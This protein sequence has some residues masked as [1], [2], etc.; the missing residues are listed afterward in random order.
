M[1]AS[2]WK[3]AIV[4][5]LLKKIG[6]ELIHSNY[7]PVSNLPFLSKCLEQCALTQFNDH[8]WKHNQILDYQSAYREN[9]SCETAL[10]II[11]DD[12]LW[13]MEN[14]EVTALMALGLLVVFNTVD[15]GILLRVL[16][17]S[18]SLR[19]PV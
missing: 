6:L 16:Q 4:R 12:I 2:D 19:E 7:R 3:T 5:P 11:V 17:K 13:S 9:Y 15:H 14:C 10:I 18:L 8:C 1:F